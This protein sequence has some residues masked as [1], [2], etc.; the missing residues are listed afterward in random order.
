[1]KLYDVSEHSKFDYLEESEK[2][3]ISKSYEVLRSKEKELAKIFYENLFD[4]APLIEPM[5]TAPIETLHN[6]FAYIFKATVKNINNFSALETMLIE[7]GRKHNT[8][9][10]NCN[11]Y[12]VVRSALMLALQYCLREK[13]NLDIEL[14]WEKYIKQIES[15]MRFDS[16]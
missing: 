1:M 13:S 16:L 10:V 4:M 14:A 7:L 6:H 2:E 11:H 8:Y 9:G 5:F 12:P 3:L 15:L